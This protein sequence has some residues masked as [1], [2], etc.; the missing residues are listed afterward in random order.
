MFEVIVLLQ[1]NLGTI[2]H[3]PDI[4]ADKHTSCHAKYLMIN[5]DTT[6]P[7]DGNSG[8]QKKCNSADERHIML[9]FL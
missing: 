8:Q 7:D 2:P 1:N 5:K 4:Q 6:D 9:T 3:V